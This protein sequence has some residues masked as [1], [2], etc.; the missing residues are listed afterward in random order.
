MQRS[1][2]RER[3]LTPLV[4]AGAVVTR[5][6]RP[7]ARTARTR[8]G[9]ARWPWLMRDE[10]KAFIETLR[11]SLGNRLD[12]SDGALHVGEVVGHA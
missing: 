5:L 7:E 3:G 10:P 2:S 1:T 4:R 8:F 12:E 6:M 11:R 9:R